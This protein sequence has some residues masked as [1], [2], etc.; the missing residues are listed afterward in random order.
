[1]ILACR[2]L[3]RAN[4]AADKIKIETNNENVEVEQLDLASL[5]SIR[6]FVERFKSKHN[7]LDILINNA[8]I[9]I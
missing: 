7:R 2:D 9:I 3:N 8:G 4:T 5:E 1:M 6:N